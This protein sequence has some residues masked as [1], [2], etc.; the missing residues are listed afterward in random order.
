MA[1]SCVAIVACLA[2]RLPS[3]R[4]PPASL[5]APPGQAR[6]STT[7]SSP[8]IP[9]PHDADG[10]GRDGLDRHL[11]V[12]SAPLAVCARAGGRRAQ[13]GAGRSGGVPSG[14]PRP[15]LDGRVLAGDAVWRASRLTEACRYALVDVGSHARRSGR[16]RTPH[17]TGQSAATRRT[18]SADNP[19]GDPGAGGPGHRPR[20]VHAAAE[21]CWP[22]QRPRVTHYSV[23]G[24][25]PCSTPPSSHTRLHDA[26]VADVS[27][28]R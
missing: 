7:T 27:V 5:T 15:S 9:V 2:S 25:A 16:Q 11:P 18:I 12:R 19:A 6:R 14:R 4:G 26:Q 20:A 28:G 13:V 1:R 8:G 10:H 21:R 23:A 3:C 22:G 24:V 17:L